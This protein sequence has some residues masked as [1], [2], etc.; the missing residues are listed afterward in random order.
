MKKIFKA[1]FRELHAIHAYVKKVLA[2]YHVD[3]KLIFKAMLI[4]EEITTN[5]SRYAYPEDAETD[6]LI[7]M[8]IRIIDENRIVMAF[9]D[10]GAAFDPLTYRKPESGPEIEIGGLGLMLV[11]KMSHRLAYRRDGNRNITTATIVR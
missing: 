10:D 1:D 6:H 7:E 3:E 2:K 5:I 8:D 9:T 4:S 11:K